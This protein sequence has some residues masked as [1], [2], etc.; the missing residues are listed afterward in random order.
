MSQWESAYMKNQDTDIA[1]KLLS[2]TDSARHSLIDF[3]NPSEMD[4]DKL[5]NVVARIER[6]VALRKR[7]KA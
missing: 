3:L 4:S 2:M 6:S 5:D 1:S 7:A